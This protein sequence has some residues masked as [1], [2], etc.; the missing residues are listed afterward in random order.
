MQKRLGLAFAVLCSVP[1][2]M[3]LSNS[4]LIPVLPMMRE[5]MDRTLFQIGLI[6]TAFSVP[7]GLFIPIGGY[8]SDRW[9]RKTVMIPGLVGFGLG[10]LAAG[11]APLFARDPYGWILAGRVLQGLSAGGM[12]QVAL[13]AAGDMFQGGARTRAM[14]ILEASNGLGKIASPILGSALSLL[15]WYAPFFAYPALAAL[16]ALGLWWLVPEPQRPGEAP[17]PG[18]YLRRMGRIFQAKGAS[19][20]VS[21]L[22][23]FTALFM[24]FGLLSVYSD[25]LE[26][27]FGIRGFVK[28]LVVAIPVAVATITAYVS[29]IVLQERLSRYLKAVVVT[30][31]AILA[32]GTAALFL[33][34]QL[35]PMVA[36]IS[37]MGLGYG[38]ALPA[39]NTL[40]TSSVESAERGGVTALYGTVRFFGAALGPPAFGLLLPLG[41]AAMYLGSAAAVA[42][43]LGLVAAFLR[44]DVLLE[45]LP[46]RA[47]DRPAGARARAGGGLR[48]PRAGRSLPENGGPPGRR[49]GAGAGGTPRPAV[50]P[51]RPGLHHAPGAAAAAVPGRDGLAT[52]AVPAGGRAGHPGAPGAPRRGTGRSGIPPIPLGPW[53]RVRSSFPPRQGMSPAS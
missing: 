9:G 21:F 25:L 23:G 53:S 45:P 35:V 19:L 32:L 31:L 26:R 20:A 14:G 40:I 3:V 10:G 18:P 2:V 11:L 17:A 16:S 7:A 4:M 34:R 27:P 52:D 24:L 13:A 46:A 51:A 48:D 1:F 33:T 8:L 50:A 6:I 15:A 29:G 37:V 43:V 22:A 5:A 42:A 12:Y 30:G 41:R 49:G 28:G 38:L 44:Q 39:L 36:A 47:G